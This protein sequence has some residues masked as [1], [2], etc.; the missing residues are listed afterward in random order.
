MSE[1]ATGSSASVTAIQD[2]ADKVTE[3]AATNTGLARAPGSIT[4]RQDPNRPG[5]ALTI[6]HVADFC[7]RYPG[8]PVTLFTRVV[9]HEPVA[10]F[11]V[12]IEL[13][14]ALVVEEYHAVG[15]E[16]TA[17]YE[18]AS[19]QSGVFLET[20]Q[21]D[22]LVVATTTRRLARRGLIEQVK[23][24]YYLVWAVEEAQ[25]AGSSHEY[26]LRAMIEPLFVDMTVASHAW[27][28][29]G[30]G[31]AAQQVNSDTAEIAVQAKGRYLAH[32]P[33]LYEQDDFMGRFLM[34]FESFWRPIDLQLGAID[35]YFDPWLTPARFLPWLAEW[36]HL[37]LDEN[38][39]EAQQRRLLSSIMR[40]Y[41]KRGTKQA[42]Q[43]YLE[44][45]TGKRVEI[46]EHRAR[47]FR[48]GTSARLGVGVAIGTGNVPHTF[49]VRVRV[50]P[51]S[52]PPGMEG[53]EAEQEV[54]LMEQRRLRIIES[55]IESQRPAHTRYILE[56]NTD[57]G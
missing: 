35:N 31:R 54:A 30:V 42:L 39:T 29:A 37:E 11:M 12:R 38:W 16:R 21:G 2:V 53:K 15:S 23:P 25:E 28:Y 8:E 47:D 33:A 44:I 46:A 14:P 40:L 36:F 57:A 49:T 24:L 51:L 45:F 22:T 43:E 26:V 3:D 48:L 34:L 5:A 19:G 27:V 32:L 6:D 4:Q 9:V 52:P 50:A 18:V 20:Q 1:M 55:I 41:R 56:V 13:P 10:G 7:K 17:S